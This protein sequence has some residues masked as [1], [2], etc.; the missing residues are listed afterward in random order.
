MSSYSVADNPSPS[1]ESAYPRIVLMSFSI[2]VMKFFPYVFKYIL[3]RRL[4]RLRFSVIESTNIAVHACRWANLVIDQFEANLPFLFILALN[5]LDSVKTLRDIS[6]FISS[7]NLSFMPCTVPSPI[8]EAR[9][10][11]I[12]P[13][14][15]L[16]LPKTSSMRS[17]SMILH[18]M[19]LRSLPHISFNLFVWYF[20]H[21]FFQTAHCTPKTR[22]SSLWQP[23]SSPYKYYET[24][25]LVYKAPLFFVSACTIS[26]FWSGL[27]GIWFHCFFPGSLL[28]IIYSSLLQLSKNNK[29]RLSNLI[30]IRQPLQRYNCR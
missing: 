28:R 2:V 21:S 3:C 11:Y 25:L 12:S 5:V 18:N 17:R 9:F 10:L 16:P 24:F 1:R 26:S 22:K 14:Q 29:K 13:I 20:K 7:Y 4:S 8:K 27:K 30:K 15:P 6:I 19:I 23:V